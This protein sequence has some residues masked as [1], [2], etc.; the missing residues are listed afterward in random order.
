MRRQD[1]LDR[2]IYAQASMNQ[3]LVDVI[4][5]LWIGYELYVNDVFM[6]IPMMVILLKGVVWALT[7]II[8]NRTM[9]KNEE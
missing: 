6:S 9:S 7:V 4:L 2:K 3:G 5:L 8:M 1:E